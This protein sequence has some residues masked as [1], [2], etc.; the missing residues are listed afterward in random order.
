MPSKPK[1][2]PILSNKV[3]FI[4]YQLT[5]KAA[6]ISRAFNNTFRKRILDLLNK[7][8]SQTVTDIYRTLKLEQSVVS[9][10]LSILRKAGIVKSE[11]DG[12]QIYY[13]LNKIRIKQL[14]QLFSDML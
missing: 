10:H 6:Q 7:K 3:I 1:S 9:Q 4:D 2:A 11:R 12:K 5:N 13:S 14:H 8:G